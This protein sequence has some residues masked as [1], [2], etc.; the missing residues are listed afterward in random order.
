MAEVKTRSC[1][2]CKK[3]EAKPYMLDLLG[4]DDAGTF[5]AKAHERTIDL[6]DPD[7]ER[8]KRFIERGCTPPPPRK[9][10]D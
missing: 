2:V 9:P 8:L 6:C 10:K 7:L 1:D 5:T 3:F 4:Q